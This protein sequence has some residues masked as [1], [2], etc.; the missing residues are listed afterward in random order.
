MYRYHDGEWQP[1][2]TTFTGQEGGY[3]QYSVQT[4][5]FSPFVIIGQNTT[6]ATTDISG[7]DTSVGGEAVGDKAETAPEA[8]KKGIPGF[9]ILLGAMGILIAVYARKK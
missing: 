8:T 7:T 3:Y 6:G 1:L 5:G 2:E 4:T 9:G